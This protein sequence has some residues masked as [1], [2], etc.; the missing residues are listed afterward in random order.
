MASR[1]I[2]GVA[3]GFWFFCRCSPA[4]MQISFTHST[5]DACPLV[6]RLQHLAA[7]VA[8]WRLVGDYF[9]AKMDWGASRCLSECDG[10]EARI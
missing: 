4:R 3:W 10:A 7:A 5:A 6:L 8:G 1:S 9:K 2:D